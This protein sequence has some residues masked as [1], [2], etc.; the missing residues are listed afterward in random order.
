M[1]TIAE[2]ESQ[3][4]TPLNLLEK[5]IVRHII[6]INGRIS[7]SVYLD[8]E[9][10]FLLLSTAQNQLVRALIKD[11]EEI[12]NTTTAI[13]DGTDGLNVSFNRDRELIASQLRRIMY[14]TDLND[15]NISQVVGIGSLNFIPVTYGNGSSEFD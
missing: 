10:R 14:P 3:P 6:G 4:S 5:E 8:S 15:P 11:S 7:S 9:E 1:P 12:D 2:I 13:H